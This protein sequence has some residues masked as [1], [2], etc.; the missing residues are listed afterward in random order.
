[1]SK[2]AMEYMALTY[3]DRLPIVIARAF[4]Y[5]GPGQG[6]EFLVP[7]LIRHFVQKEEEI[8]LGNLEFEREFNDVRMVCDAYLRLLSKGKS[9]EAYNVCTGKVYTLPHLIFSLEKITGH[10]INVCEN[11]SFIRP[12]EVHRLYG[13]AS[14]LKGAIGELKEYA[15]TDTLKWMLKSYVD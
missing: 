14:K 8:E 3:S 13:D 10:R 11:P 1:M 5:I 7:K 9:G 12:N 15:L 2:L 4:N 6:A